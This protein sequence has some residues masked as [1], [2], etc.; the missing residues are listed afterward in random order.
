MD[1]AF[2][3]WYMFNCL[4]NSGGHAPL[5]WLRCLIEDEAGLVDKIRDSIT[6]REVSELCPYTIK[7]TPDRSWAQH[8]VDRIKAREPSVIAHVPAPDATV[9]S[10]EHFLSLAAM[11]RARGE[12]SSV[13]DEWKILLDWYLYYHGALED[14]SAVIEQVRRLTLLV[15]HVH[16][17]VRLVDRLQWVI[18]RMVSRFRSFEHVMEMCADLSPPLKELLDQCGSVSADKWLKLYDRQRTAVPV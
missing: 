15:S 10:D 6:R 11:L 18:E 8:I 12:I 4:L 17:D 2:C 16:P 1:N 3:N 14:E 7:G 13:W 9:F 5:G